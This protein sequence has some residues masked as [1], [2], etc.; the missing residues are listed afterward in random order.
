[1]DNEKSLPR[2]LFF[3]GQSELLPTLPVLLLATCSIHLVTFLIRIE[4]R[5]GWKCNRYMHEE[6]S[7][8]RIQTPLKVKD[9]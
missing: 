2:R 1:M 4:Q 5:E 3:S 7:W 6:L 8:L 9:S